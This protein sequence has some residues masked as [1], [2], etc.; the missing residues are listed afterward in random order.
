M[1]DFKMSYFN[2]DQQ[3]YMRYLATLK[4]E[5]KCACGWGKKGQCYCPKDLEYQKAQRLE[6]EGE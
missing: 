1:A 3:E 6:S 4:P 5:E 2:E